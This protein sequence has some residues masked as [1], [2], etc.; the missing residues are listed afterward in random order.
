[1]LKCNE[2]SPIIRIDFAEIPEVI[3]KVLSETINFTHP[4]VALKNIG[5]H[6]SFFLK[7]VFLY[8]VIRQLKA[9]L[10]DAVT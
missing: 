5:Y 6:Y 7:K 9:N 4:T 10:T 2:C 8:R 3:G 1:M